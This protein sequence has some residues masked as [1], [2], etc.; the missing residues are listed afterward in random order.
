MKY[1]F[2]EFHNCESFF[3]FEIEFDLDLQHR[4]DVNDKFSILILISFR[5]NCLIA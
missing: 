4:I 2:F 5:R 3:E 1:T